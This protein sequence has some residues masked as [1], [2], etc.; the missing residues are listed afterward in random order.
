M[1]Y[2]GDYIYEPDRLIFYE[3]DMPQYMVERMREIIEITDHYDKLKCG[4]DSLDKNHM[5]AKGKPIDL[6]G[7][8]L[9]YNCQ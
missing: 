2:V 7:V 8:C 4:Y 9:S 5:S 1:H 3:K 6:I